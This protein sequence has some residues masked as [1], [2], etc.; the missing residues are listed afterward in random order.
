MELKRLHFVGRLEVFIALKSYLNVHMQNWLVC[1]VQCVFVC[2]GLLFG[3]SCTVCV[4]VC[5][6]FGW[7]VLYS[8]CLCGSFGWCVL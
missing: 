4:C 7:C 6:S 3:V 8:V 2:V 5:G 1:L